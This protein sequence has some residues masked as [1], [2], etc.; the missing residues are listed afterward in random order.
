[1][2]K[3]TQLSIISLSIIFTIISAPVFAKK[4]VAPA[5][6]PIVVQTTNVQFSD[7]PIYIDALGSLTAE[8]SVTITT[9][10]DGRIAH[11]FFS[12]GQQVGKNMPIIQQDNSIEQ[13]NY[14]IAVTSLNLDRSILKRWQM[15]PPGTMSAADIAKQKAQIDTDQATVQ[16]Q[17]ATLNQK[18]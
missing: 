13:A 16:L 3:T 6:K 4:K 14:N 15:L 11:I 7:V 2:R 18:H 9:E 5:I 17:Q 12:N 10:T 8:Q 1:M